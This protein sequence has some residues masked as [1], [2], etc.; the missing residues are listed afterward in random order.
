A[1]LELARHRR[2]QRARARP[3]GG[4]RRRSTCDR[5]GGYR[6]ARPVVALHPHLSAGTAGGGAE[7]H[8]RS[9]ARLH[10]GAGV[11]VMSTR[12]LSTADSSTAVQ[13]QPTY[14]DGLAPPRLGFL[15][16][17]WIGRNRMEAIHR[18]G[19]GIVAMIC[20]PAATV[21]AEAAAVAPEAEVVGS[22][23]Q[24]LAAGLDGIV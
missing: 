17:G 23:D 10:Q 13:R 16:A 7:R 14:A 20:D 8:P 11:H 19:A 6:C 1:A 18:S 3:R 22:F 4:P 24:M 15:G 12:T 9:A 5:G 21:A 2:D